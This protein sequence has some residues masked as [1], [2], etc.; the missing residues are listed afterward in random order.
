MRTR[1]RQRPVLLAAVAAGVA[2]GPLAALFV[3]AS[4][5]VLVGWCAAATVYVVVS[6]R[7]MS[8]ATPEGMRRRAALLEEGKWAVLAASVAAA[9]ASLGAVVV[10]LTAAWGS[11]ALAAVTILLSWSFVHV[12]FAGHYA[13]D[14]WLA[15]SG[16]EF[17][18]NER[19]DYAEFLYLAFVVGM[20][21]QV[22]DVT[23]ASAAMRR[24]VL[25]HGLVSFL[26][27]AV[28]VGAA[29]NI[30]AGVVR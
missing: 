27:N 13:H 6:L 15:G 22:S 23:T 8:L 14:Y 18:G 30:A 12:L 11:P 20:T 9:V 19:P 10:D 29:V 28:I 7:S 5:A 25:L 17:P 24:L 4:A 3:P 2:A 26:F 1:L 16:L 21:C